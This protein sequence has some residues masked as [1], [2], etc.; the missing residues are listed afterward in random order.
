MIN[1]QVINI[2]L[3]AD[4]NY[5]EQVITLIKSVCYHH[6]NVRFYLIQQDY[7]DEWFDALNKHLVKLDAEI[8]PATILDSFEF[9]SILQKH[10]TQASFYRYLIPKI[11]EERILYLDS[12]IVVDGNIEEMYFSDFNEKY[13][14]AVEDMYISHTKHCYMEFPEMKPYF[15]SGVLLINNKLW[16]EYDLFEHLIQTTKAYPKVIYGDQDILNILL[17]NKWEILSNVYNYQTGVMYGSLP[18]NKNLSNEE[19]LEKYQKQAKE[20]QPKII[21]YTSKYKPWLNNE[22]FVLLRE[23]YWFYYQL[24]WEEIKKHHQEFFV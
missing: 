16:Q 5:A 2:A 4:R 19:I 20:V 9:D 23:K 12:D 15:N 7:P 18:V 21:H 3:A 11:P 14:F 8:I 1:K 22:Y 17:K 6:K 24:S 10:I 13:A